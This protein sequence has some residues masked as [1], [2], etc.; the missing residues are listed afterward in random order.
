MA[1]TVLPFIDEV[2]SK[3]V[4][5]TTGDPIENIGKYPKMSCLTPVQQGFA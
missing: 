4:G 5:Q 2:S 3:S 1:H